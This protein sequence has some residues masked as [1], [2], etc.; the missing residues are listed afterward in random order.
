MNGVRT[1]FEFFQTTQSEKIFKL[2]K[3]LLRLKTAELP[4]TRNLKEKFVE[5]FW[6]SKLLQELLILSHKF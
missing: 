1:N 4:Y 2:N 3:V 6:K 5:S